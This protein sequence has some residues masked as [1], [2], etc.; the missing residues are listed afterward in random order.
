MTAR[1]VTPRSPGRPL[2]A[3]LLAALALLATAAAALLSAATH[4]TSETNDGSL[5][6]VA[7]VCLAVGVV[8]SLRQPANPIGWL[9]LFVALSAPL[10]RGAT[11]YVLFDFH[12]HHGAL[13]AGR[14]A[15]F[16]GNTL[17]AAPIFL[18]GPVLLLFPDGTAGHRARFWLKVYGVLVAV[19][20][21]T[22]AVA[23]AWIASVPHFRVGPT[24]PIAI[25]AHP[26]V[27]VEF[28]GSGL[29][30]LLVF[31]FW[32]GC[33]VRLLRDLRSSTG[34]RRQQLKWFTAGAAIATVGVAVNV[35]SAG[36]TTTAF[37]TVNVVMLYGVTALPLGI[38]L[39]ILRYRLY[40][41]DRLISQTISYAAVTIVLVGAYAGVVLLS[42][43]VLPFSSA[44]GVAA[45][46][47][48]VAAL[49][50]PLRRRVQARVDRRFNRARYD[51]ERTV[52]QFAG[53]LRD[54]VD[55]S[56]V[57]SDLLGV[58]T[59]AFEPTV[60]SLWLALHDGATARAVPTLAPARGSRPTGAQALRTSANA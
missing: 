13:P 24:G 14:A 49:F 29:P 37:T 30:V 42:T 52:S 41:I 56:R 36:R 39:G 9:M 43:K 23:A 28:F 7:L 2:I 6:A 35:A 40:D 55:P 22:Q 46:T 11:L 3:A 4:D 57:E 50:N 53:G 34:D 31:P 48:A 32:A 1:V 47:L 27:L 59:T 58:V 25:G 26:F 60:A 21:A 15:V 5:L 51:A 54:A 10:T 44:V 38:G 45:S 12:L 33:L 18:V 16:F 17:W 20:L 8:V 19:A